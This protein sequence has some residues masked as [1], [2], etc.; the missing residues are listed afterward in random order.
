LLADFA[1]AA[2]DVLADRE[3]PFWLMIESGD[4]D[5][6]NHS[7]NIDNSVGAVISGDE[8]FRAVTD[9]IERRGGWNDTALILTADHGHYLVID[10]P[11]MLV[12]PKVPAAQSAAQ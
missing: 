2:L 11:E 7:N 3:K 6:A 8:A 12:G 1:I 9:W 5:W 10:K 4:V